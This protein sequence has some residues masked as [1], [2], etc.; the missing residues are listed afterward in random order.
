MKLDN[1]PN[2]HIPTYLAPYAK[3]F[4][5]TD[6]AQFTLC[7]S[8]GN[9]LFEV[10]YYGDFFEVKGKEQ[11][12]IVQTDS[13]P[14]LIVVRNIATGEQIIVHNGAIHGYNS[15]FCDEFDA[16]VIANRP[17]KKYPIPP[18]K[19]IVELGYGID[20]DDE[21]EDYDVDDE[22]Y[23]TLVDGRKMSWEDLKRNGMD[24]IGIS[25]ENRD[26]QLIEF[27]NKELA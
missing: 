3:D 13:A 17:L 14:E 10:W 26:G 4:K 6:Y 12:F 5:E 23:A 18:S 22:G 19:L 27:Y 8:A 2:E 24:F 20:Y 21:K 15:M 11:P 25:Y 16:E 1:N 9:E 7:S